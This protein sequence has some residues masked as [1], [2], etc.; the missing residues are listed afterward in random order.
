MPIDACVCGRKQCANTYATHFLSLIAPVQYTFF[1]SKFFY[2]SFY[3]SYL[4]F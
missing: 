3:G 2:I 4:A 1:T